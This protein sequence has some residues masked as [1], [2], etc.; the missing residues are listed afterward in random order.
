M[1]GRERRK[2]LP[3]IISFHSVGTYPAAEG[4][5]MQ[6]GGPRLEWPAANWRRRAWSRG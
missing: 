5:R 2:Y 1:I 4:V 3:E 6:G